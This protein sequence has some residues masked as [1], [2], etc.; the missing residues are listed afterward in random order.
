MLQNFK[1]FWLRDW[2][3]NVQFS[4]IQIS[5]Y[6]ELS[7]V[8]KFMLTPSH[9]QVSEQCSFSLNSNILKTNT[10]LEN[11]ITKQLI[12]NHIVVNNWK[13]HTIKITNPMLKAFRSAHSSYNTHLEEVKKE[14]S[15][16]RINFS[17]LHREKLCEKNL[18]VLVSRKGHNG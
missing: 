17:E 6:Q 12:I 7:F 15:R 3:D 1:A 2:L 14:I 13:P 5:K 4:T 9:C 11:V 10:G 18:L 16:V 8:L